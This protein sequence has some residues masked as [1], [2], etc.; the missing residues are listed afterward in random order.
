MIICSV[1]NKTTGD[2]E[3]YHSLSAAKKAMKELIKQGY[4]VSGSKMK[5]W[6]NGDFEP[7]GNITLS[8]N[9]KHFI[10]NTKQRKEGY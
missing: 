4:E 7:L 6:T 10:A 1:R 9:N 8:G 2:F 3:E 5:V